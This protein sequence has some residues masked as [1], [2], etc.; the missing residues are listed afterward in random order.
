MYDGRKACVRVNGSLSEWFD[1]DSGVRQGCVMSPWLFNVFMDGVMKEVRMRINGMGIGLERDGIEW[2]LSDL[3]Y[4]DDVVFMAKSERE[5]S[6]MI[7]KFD[8]VCKRR[9]LKVNV[10]KSKVMVAETG[11][12]GHKALCEGL[13]RKCSLSSS[14]A[15]MLVVTEA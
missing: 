7:Q 8:Y 4:A 6:V 5:L 3:M 12:F 15:V 13:W 14:L 9:G 1:I 10:D 2:T 11:A